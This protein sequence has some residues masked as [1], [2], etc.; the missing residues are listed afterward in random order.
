MTELES[1]SETVLPKVSSLAI[2]RKY[3]PVANG[4]YCRRRTN[5]TVPLHSSPSLSGS[6]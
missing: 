3:P 5:A 1:K 6:R 2:F 4:T